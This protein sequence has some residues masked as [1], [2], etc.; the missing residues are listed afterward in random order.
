MRT[1]YGTKDVNKLRFAML[2]FRFKP[3]KEKIH[4]MIMCV[5]DGS[6]TIELIELLH[7]VRTPRFVGLLRGVGDGTVFDQLL[8]KRSI[9]RSFAAMDT[10]HDGHVTQDPCA[11]EVAPTNF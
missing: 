10:R 1:S 8:H 9:L 7:A 5:D 4:K 3:K 2:A 6:G 11:S